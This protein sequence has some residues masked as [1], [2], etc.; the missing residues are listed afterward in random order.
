MANSIIV[1]FYPRPEAE[2]AARVPFLIFL[3]TLFEGI[4]IAAIYLPYKRFCKKPE[5][6]PDDEEKKIKDEKMKEVYTP[7]EM[8]ERKGDG[9][10]K[11]EGAYANQAFEKN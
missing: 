7:E 5:D 6:G 9:G 2:L 1:L 4:I 11:D 8:K 3:M 10:A